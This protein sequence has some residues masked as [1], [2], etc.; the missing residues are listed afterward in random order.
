[1]I[2]HILEKIGAK[3]CNLI[4]VINLILNPHFFYIPFVAWKNFF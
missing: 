1:M 2:S 3:L 4:Y